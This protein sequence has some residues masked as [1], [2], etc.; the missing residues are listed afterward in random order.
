MKDAMVHM[1]DNHEAGAAAHL[2]LENEAG[3]STEK[4]KKRRDVEVPTS[5]LVLAFGDCAE[6]AVQVIRA[7]SD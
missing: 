3:P 6:Q 7:T 1:W 5:L 2:W 4:R